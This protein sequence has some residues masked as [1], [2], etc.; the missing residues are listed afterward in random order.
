MQFDGLSRERAQ[1]KAD[2]AMLPPSS[3]VPPRTS[4]SKR[5]RRRG[6]APGGDPLTTTTS[7]CPRSE[8][9]ARESPDS[10]AP[11]RVRLLFAVTIVRAAGAGRQ[12]DRYA[13]MRDQHGR[14]SR[15]GRRGTIYDRTG[16]PLA[17]ASRRRPFTRSPQRRRRPG[18]AVVT[19]RC[20]AERRRALPAAEEPL[21]GVRLRR[22]QGRPR[23]AEALRKLELSGLGFYPE[24]LRTTPGRVAAHVLGFAAPTTTAS[25]AWSARSTRPCPE[26]GYETIVKDPYGA[27]STSSRPGRAPGPQRDAHHRPQ[28]QSNAEQCSPGR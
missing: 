2:N 25:T 24:E 23:K 17:S 10:P 12:H 22:A 4:A 5:R 21:Q 19:R 13:K 11:R 27:R 7:G 15:Y 18:A 20:S 26:V 3:R 9:H 14:R 16:E 8:S 6:S 28:I 1:L